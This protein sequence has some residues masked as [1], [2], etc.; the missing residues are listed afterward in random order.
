NSQKPVHY[1]EIDQSVLA[2]A[3]RFRYRTDDGEAHLLPQG[4]RVLIGADDRV[5]LHGEKA[6]PAGLVERMRAERT[7]DAA[8][9]ALGAHHVAGVGDVGAETRLIGL[10]NVRP[11]DFAVAKSD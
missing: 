5:E 7:A 2:M 10:E 1:V 4:H 6:C 11:D 3:K 8:S 9:A